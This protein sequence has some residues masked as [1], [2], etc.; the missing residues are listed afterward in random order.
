[1]T[2]DSI[3]GLPSCPLK[4]SSCKVENLLIIVKFQ[5]NADSRDFIKPQHL[6]LKKESGKF[7]YIGCPRPFLSW[8]QL[9]GFSCS[10]WILT[11]EFAA[12]YKKWWKPIFGRVASSR[13]ELNI[14]WLLVLDLCWQAIRN[15][16]L[17]YITQM[18]DI[19]HAIWAT[20]PVF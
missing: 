16:I 2:H 15:V 7:R 9:V 5:I 20:H 17:F 14:N 6:S 8:K 11:R 3:M 19:Q 10:S 1:M 13:P 12:E 18:S 4:T